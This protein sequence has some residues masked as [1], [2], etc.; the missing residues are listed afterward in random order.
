MRNDVSRPDSCKRP[1]AGID[2]YYEKCIIEV[3]P[4]PTSVEHILR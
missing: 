4:Y 1:D 2:R 3:Y